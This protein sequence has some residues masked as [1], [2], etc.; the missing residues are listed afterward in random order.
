[1]WSHFI[2]GTVLLTR[3]K[4]VLDSVQVGKTR[5]DL[6]LDSFKDLFIENCPEM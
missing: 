4:R 6:E 1:M 2:G 3:K 5:S